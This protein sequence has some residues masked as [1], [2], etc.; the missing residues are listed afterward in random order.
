MMK[1]VLYALL[2]ALLVSAAPSSGKSS[3]QISSQTRSDKPTDL[4]AKVDA[5]V[6]PFLEIKGF[7]GTILIASKGQVLLRK[8]YGMANYD[9][10]VPN[11]PRTKFH[12]ASISKSF[13]A[14]AILILEERGLLGV[15]DPLS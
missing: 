12:L 5:Y 14:A 13:T 3:G 9:L 4:E 7:S 8:G 11:T 6:K 1:R 15:S 10:D 2:L